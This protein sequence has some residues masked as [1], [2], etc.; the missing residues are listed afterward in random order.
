MLILDL[1]ATRKATHTHQLI[2]NITPR[3]TCGKRKICS[4]IE[5]FE[6]IMKMIAA[7]LIQYHVAIV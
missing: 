6:N 3:F 2:I 7:L 1:L 5:K 4:I